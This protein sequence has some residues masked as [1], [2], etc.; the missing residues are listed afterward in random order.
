MYKTFRWQIV[1]AV[2][3]LLDSRQKRSLVN[4][5]SLLDNSQLTRQRVAKE[6]CLETCVYTNR[7][8]TFL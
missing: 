2:T 4:K 3:N 7:L 5:L 1:L 6:T 8:M